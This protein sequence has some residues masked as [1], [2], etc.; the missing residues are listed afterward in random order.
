MTIIYLSRVDVISKQDTYR[1]YTKG[2]EGYRDNLGNQSQELHL[3][4]FLDTLYQRICDQYLPIDAKT[5][6][7]L[8]LVMCCVAVYTLILNHKQLLILDK[9]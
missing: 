9:L 8:L 2:G 7:K 6:L 4:A 3:L 5:S 1:S